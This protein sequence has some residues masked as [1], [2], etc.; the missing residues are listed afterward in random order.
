MQMGK[1]K[2]INLMKRLTTLFTFIVFVLTTFNTSA[3]A[4]V[5]MADT[6]R[7]SGKIYVVV[8]ILVLILVGLFVYV[9][10]MDRKI[11]KLEEKVNER[12]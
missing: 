1:S 12:A 3:Q 7:A 11:S 9:F 4:E 5:E 8:A 6:M 2:K 10:L